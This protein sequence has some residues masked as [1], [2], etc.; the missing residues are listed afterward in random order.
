MMLE[1]GYGGGITVC[2]WAIAPAGCKRHVCSGEHR[3]C[4]VARVFTAQ[5]N[6]NLLLWLAWGST[7]RDC[8]VHFP[9]KYI[10]SAGRQYGNEAEIILIGECQ[11]GERERESRHLTTPDPPTSVFH[12][13]SCLLQRLPSSIQPSQAPSAPFCCPATGSSQCSRS[14]RDRLAGLAPAN[15]EE[16][17]SR[18][19]G[20]SE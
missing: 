17:R 10:I 9:T 19:G 20:G 4:A 1:A 8:T 3:S 16:K 14:S 5:H 6:F 2:N 11:P 12:P 18:L 13:S 15:N 7:G